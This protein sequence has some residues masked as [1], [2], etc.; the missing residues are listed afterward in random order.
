MPKGK[1][2][3]LSSSCATHLPLQITF[4]FP[5]S[6]HKE[7]NPAIPVLAST[8]LMFTLHTSVLHT[9]LIQLGA[10]RQG[11]RH[12][13][14]NPEQCGWAFFSSITGCQIALGVFTRCWCVGYP[15]GGLEAGNEDD[16]IRWCRATSALPVKLR[17]EMGLY[18][19]F[20]VKSKV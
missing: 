13:P 19:W 9:N 11:A 20:A 12:R 5:H 4:F 8:G 3:F 1:Y 14:G 18:V 6:F 17:Q 16:V 2:V 7:G 10:N 15:K